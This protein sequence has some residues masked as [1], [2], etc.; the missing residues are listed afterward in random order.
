MNEE[1]F[2]LFRVLLKNVITRGMAE[3]EAE[4]LGKIIDENKHSCNK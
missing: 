2:S 1:D 3:E 4:E